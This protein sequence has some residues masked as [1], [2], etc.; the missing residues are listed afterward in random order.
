MRQKMKLNQKNTHVLNSYHL[1]N[2]IASWFWCDDWRQ[3]I[4]RAYENSFDCLMENRIIYSVIYV[5]NC[6][7]RVRAPISSLYLLYPLLTIFICVDFTR[8]AF[9]KYTLSA[10]LVGQTF[11]SGDSPQKMFVYYVG[12]IYVKRKHFFVYYAPT[13]AHTLFCVNVEIERC[14]VNI[15]TMVA[16]CKM[17][18]LRNVNI[19][20]WKC[21]WEICTIV[22]HDPWPASI[23]YKILF[24]VG[25][26]K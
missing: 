26:K 18:L 4:T 22:F 6:P 16:I 9:A 2:A 13:R 20:F 19:L 1:M 24:F 14:D 10:Q 3:D 12:I 7:V 5:Y 11:F 15:S 25:G 8:I 17:I 21:S 23:W